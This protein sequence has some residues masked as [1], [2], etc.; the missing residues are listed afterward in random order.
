MVDGIK[1]GVRRR[2]EKSENANESFSN[3]TDNSPLLN[4]LNNRVA[5]QRQR[6]L[7]AEQV[8]SHGIPDELRHVPGVALLQ[9]P[10]GAALPVVLS[11]PGVIEDQILGHVITTPLVLLPCPGRIPGTCKN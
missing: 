9:I 11:L 10:E 7:D 1:K 6:R 5:E 3:S 4:T 8:S 2:I